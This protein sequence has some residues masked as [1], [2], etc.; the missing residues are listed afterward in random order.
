[1]MNAIVY[2]AG[3]GGRLGGGFGKPHKLLLEFGGRTL[4][5]WHTKNL[6]A[7][8][9]PRLFVV[10][11][12]NHKALAAEFGELRRRH[13]IEI[14]ELFNPDFC[15]GSVLSMRASLGVLKGSASPVLLMD[16][17]V[18]Y[19]VGMLRRLIESA[20]PTALLIDRAYS[21][22]DDDPVLVPVRD[23]KPFEFLKAWKGEADVV[24]ESVGFFKVDPAD[25]PMVIYETQI[26]SSGAARAESYDAVLRAMVRAGRFG[27]ED[28]TGMPWT[29]I[30]F[31]KDIE[32]ARERV[33]PALRQEID[34]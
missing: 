24:G 6:A 12:Y 21:T 4:L 20:H 22:E 34:R 32:D 33:W 2:A 25:L 23:G 3:R 19:G 5:E 11:G 9:V 29:E 8:G 27:V 13:G 17:D 1:M 14:L 28:V 7:A 16:G 15:E 26:R 30:D 10:T 31:P 18:L